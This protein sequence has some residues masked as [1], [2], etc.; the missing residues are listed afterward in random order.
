MPIHELPFDLPMNGT[1][2]PAIGTAP[3]AMKIGS[4]TRMA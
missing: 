2:L 4:L 3:M 1:I